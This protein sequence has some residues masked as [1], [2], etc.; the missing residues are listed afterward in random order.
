MK[1]SLREPEVRNLE[2][3]LGLGDQALSQVVQEAWLRGARF[4]GWS[5]HFDFARWEEAFA[6][7]GIDPELYVAPRDPLGGVALGPRWTVG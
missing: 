1:V 7:V 2:G 3:V 5:E 6:Q 4:D